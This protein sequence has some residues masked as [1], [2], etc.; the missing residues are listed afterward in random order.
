MKRLL[1]GWL[2]LCLVWAGIC[3][4]AAE[5]EE[6]RTADELSAEDL[7]EIEALDEDDLYG[8]RVTG[9]VYPEPTAADF[10]ANSPA[11]YTCK[12]LTPLG[13]PGPAF[14]SGDYFPLLPWFCLYLCGY[15]LLP[16][17]QRS[18]HWRKLAAL[19]CAP[20]GWVGRRSLWI[21][22]LHQP[23]CMGLAWL[24]FR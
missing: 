16:L 7:A 22:M 19:R 1:C 5:G 20:L 9:K 24:L 13:F 23:L 8:E 18:A 2:C 12:V 21:Y 17:L 6:P 14:R 4:A 10:N 11:L 15:F 3:F